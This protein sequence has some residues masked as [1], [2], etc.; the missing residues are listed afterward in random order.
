[1]S[2]L[3]LVHVLTL[4]LTP[5]SMSRSFLT[6]IAGVTLAIAIPTMAQTY[7]STFP[8]V[9]ADSSSAAD[10]E[11]MAELGIIRGYENGWFGPNNSVTRAQ[12]AIMLNRYDQTV[13]QPLRDQLNA[14]NK[15]LGLNQM[16]NGHVVGD[17][18]KSP[19]GCNTCTCTLQ[20]EICTLRACAPTSKSSSSKS[21]SRAS[22]KSSGAVCDNAICEAGEDLYCPPCEPGKVCAQYCIAGSCMRDCRASSSSSVSSAFGCRPYMC[23]DGTTIPA[24]TDDGHVINY[25]A[26]PCMTHGGESQSSR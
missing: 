15:E 4:N 19:D 13:I 8:D 1:M 14:I 11:R 21:S 20:G 9:P 22:S 12:V 5:S 23:N 16:C 3:H 6:F 25:F 17:A 26:P 10:I 24:C 18:Y 7:R 2:F